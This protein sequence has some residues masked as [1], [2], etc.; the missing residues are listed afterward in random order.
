ML[1]SF[2]ICFSISSKLLSNTTVY[3]DPDT[4]SEIVFKYPSYGNCEILTQISN[5]SVSNWEYVDTRVFK[6]RIRDSNGLWLDDEY[7]KGWVLKSNLTY[8]NFKK[9]QLCKESY[10]EYQ[11][12]DIACKVRIYSNGTYHILGNSYI[13]GFD[14]TNQIYYYHDILYFEGPGW[15]NYFIF[16]KNKLRMFV[17]GETNNIKIE[18]DK[19]KFKL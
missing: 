6:K 8:G 17:E 3:T 16:N 11:I 12:G 2:G 9:L 13:E 14:F 1:F 15:P 5:M 18:Y 10:F 7:Y 4:N 19:K